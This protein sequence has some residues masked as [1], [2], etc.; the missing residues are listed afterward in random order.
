MKKNIVI[1]V[2]VVAVILLVLWKVTQDNGR[3]DLSQDETVR[4]LERLSA[5]TPE[6]EPLTTEQE[7]AL[8]GLSAPQSQKSEAQMRQEEEALRLLEGK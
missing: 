8:Q 2:V 6:E 7:K 3:Q 5:P 4:A 1:S